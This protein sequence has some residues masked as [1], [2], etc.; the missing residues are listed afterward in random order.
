VL[1][2]ILHLDHMCLLLMFPSFQLLD[3]YHEIKYF[4][5]VLLYVSRRQE[6]YFTWSYY[7]KVIDGVIVLEIWYIMDITQTPPLHLT[8]TTYTC[9]MP[10]IFVVTIA[11]NIVLHKVSE[12]HTC[13]LNAYS[14]F[15]CNKISYA[16]T[17]YDP[18]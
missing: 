2:L 13:L 11:A 18:C 17:K 9:L 16:P 15:I 8:P 6:I 7:M 14:F 10:R 12:F 4:V 1:N 3:K 5:N